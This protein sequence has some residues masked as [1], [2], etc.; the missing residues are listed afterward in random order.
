MSTIFTVSMSFIWKGQEESYFDTRK[1]LR[2]GDS[3][4]PYLFVTFMDKLSHMIIN[5]IE[6]GKCNGIK[7]GRRGTMITHLMFVDN[8]LLF[9]RA[10]EKQMGVIKDIL[11]SLCSI[12]G[13]KYQLGKV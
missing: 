3:I 9:G 11:Y 13:K 2:Y 6:E 4:S 12:S 5:V 8:L 10:C 1:G 7:A